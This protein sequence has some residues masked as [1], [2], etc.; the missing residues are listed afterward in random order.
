MS[1]LFAI[2]NAAIQ[3]VNPNVSGTIYRSTGSTTSA[4]GRRTPTYDA[5]TPVDIQTQGS[6]SAPEVAQV[7]GLN[8]QGEVEGIYLLGNWRGAVKADQVG[9]DKVVYGDKTWMVVH[10]LENWDDWTKVVVARIA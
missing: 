4:S 3:G 6:L 1:G 9:G 10:I 2:S 8:I 7:Q 5:G